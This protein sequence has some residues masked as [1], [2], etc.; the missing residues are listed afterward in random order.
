MT[1]RRILAAN[2]P[3]KPN[4]WPRTDRRQNRI[5]EVIDRRQPDLMVILENVHDPHNVSA[6]LRSCDAVGVLKIALIYTVESPPT[7]FARTTSGSAAKWIEIQSFNSVDECFSALNA[8]G[9]TIYATA[10][11]E[12][13]RDLFG[14]DFTKPAAIAFGN[15]MRGL[16][17]EA[18]EKADATIEIPMVG[19]VRSLNISVA[20]AVTLYEAFRQRRVAGLYESPKL[21]GNARTLLVDDWLNR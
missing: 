10:L 16:S 5:E 8:E 7:A 13:S 9:F 2:Q 15:E 17:K 20:C 14:V 12:S 3:P 21:T 1:D 6:V 18:I 4:K 11:G 19:M